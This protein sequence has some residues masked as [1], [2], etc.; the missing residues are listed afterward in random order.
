M[1]TIDRTIFV[2]AALPIFA[3]SQVAFADG[4]LVIQ[5]WRT[6]AGWLT[7]L[8]QHSDGARVCT[9][10]KAFKDGHPFGISI[11]K[12]GQITLVTLVDEIQPPSRGGMMQLSSSG[13]DVGTLS[14]TPEGPAF[15]TTE[16]ESEKTWNMISGLPP[17]MLSIAVDGRQYQAN[18]DG[19]DQA[20]DQLKVCERQAAS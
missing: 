14:V 11:V 3:A 5:S 17:Q 8:R 18:L 7:E 4:S 12:S 13:Q 2:L 1:K 6:D 10:G 15:A 16:G 9:T 20:R 19:I